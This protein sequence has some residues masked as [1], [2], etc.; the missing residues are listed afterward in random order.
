M[1]KII[2]TELQRLISKKGIASRKEATQMILE[3]LV[4]VNGQICL[5]PTK[6]FDPRVLIEISG[7][8][9]IS[10]AKFYLALHKPQGL[11]VTRSDEKGRP[12]VYDC[13]IDW[14]GPLLQAVG[15][16][17]LASEGLLL[18]T[19]DHLWAEKLTNP[20]THLKKIYHVQVTPIPDK[21][22]LDKLSNGIMLEEQ[23]TLPAKFEIIRTGDKN[24][25]LGIELIEGRNR[26]IRKMLESVGIDVLRLIRVQ[27]GK[28]ELGELPK[29]KWYEINKD[30]V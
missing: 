14:Q 26:Q 30:L 29:G 19:N 3:G 15:R 5:M 2:K 20:T 16:L 7:Q 8:K 10:A 6:G 9:A 24:A 22:T 21:N 11:V 25:W 27:I 4:K 17:D 18:F 28:L 1:K 13:L 12:T 23:K